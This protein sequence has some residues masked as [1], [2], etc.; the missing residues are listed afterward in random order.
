MLSLCVLVDEDDLQRIVGELGR[1]VDVCGLGLCLGLRLSALEKIKVDE[2]SLEKQKI[3]MLHHWLTRKDIIRD[4]QGEVPRWSELADAV[5]KENHVLG[6][7]IR[8]KYC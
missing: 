2:H 6:Q 5:A 1:V 3:K 4:K 8:D 7:Q